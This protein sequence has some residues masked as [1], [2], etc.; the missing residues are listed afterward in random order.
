MTFKTEAAMTLKNVNLVSA[1][2]RS[3]VPALLAALLAA[4]LL[5]GCLP[6]IA[7]GVAAGALAIDDR[8]S[9]GTQT[10]DKQIGFS[11]DKN[12]NDVY[13]DRVHV[14]I[15]PFNRRV[16]LTGEV[17]DEKTRQD[18]ANI[19]ARTGNVREVINEV[20]VGPNASISARSNDAFITSKVKGNFVDDQQLLANA[21]KVTTEAT[22]VY[23]QGLV[24]RE[25][26]DRASNVAARTNGVTKVVRVFEYIEKAPR[27]TGSPAGDKK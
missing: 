11:V 21:F 19:A 17:P 2:K 8:R 26:G 18:V 10:D 5:Q 15:N 27:T 14:N 23:L 13:G 6:V 12:I 16:L 1:V 22:V 20:V 3:T 7:G 4:P 25:E 9:L 24:T